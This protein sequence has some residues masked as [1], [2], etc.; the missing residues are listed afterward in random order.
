MLKVKLRNILITHSYFYLNVIQDPDI[1]PILGCTDPIAEN[2]NPSATEDDGSCEYMIDLSLDSITINEYCDGFTPYWIPTLHLNNLTNPAINEY[3]IKVQ[4]LGQTNDTICFNAMGTTINSFGDISLEWP[5]PIYSY[6]TISIHVLDVNGESENSWE[7]FGEDWNISNNTLVLVIGNPTINCDVLGCTDGTANNFNPN[8]NVDDGSCT[9][10]IYGCTDED[11]NNFNPDANVDD[12]S[13]TYDIFGCTDPEA[14]NYD[15]T[16]NVDDGSCTYD[17]YGCTDSD[18]NNYNPSATVD[19]GSCTYD[20][21]GCTDESANN[22]NPSAT[23]DDGSCE[24]D[25]VGCTDS[26][27]N[28]YNPEANVDD[29]SCE[30]DVFGCTDNYNPNANV[31]DGSCLYNIFGCTDPLALNYNISANIDDGTCLYTQVLVMTFEGL[32]ISHLTHL[33]TK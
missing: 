9:Y 3:C 30:Y 17:I 24:Y 11:A 31:D 4:V 14:N 26:T 29:G 1:C 15:S 18:A 7:D 23:V 32:C 6:G 8:A 33:V 28:N 22:Y 16:A 27:A 21:Y 12:G 5:E 25:V 13:C 20:V 10:D 19:D 2:Y